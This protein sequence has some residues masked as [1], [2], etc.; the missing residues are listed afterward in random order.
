M[1]DCCRPLTW[2]KEN[3][4][5]LAEFTCL[6]KC[7][8]LDAKT[9]FADQTYVFLSFGLSLCLSAD[10]STRS[11][12]EFEQAIKDCTRS[13]DQFIAVSY[14][15]AS[16]GQTGIGHF[17]PAGGYCSM[18]G[19]MVLILDVAR[20]K[21]GSQNPGEVSL[22][23]WED[24]LRIGFQ[25]GCYTNPLSLTTWQRTSHGKHPRPSI[26]PP[27]DVPSG[28]SI[29][30][31]PA[32]TQPVPPLLTL[33]ATT[34][35]WP[36]LYEP[37]AN[38]AATATSYDTL[39]DTLNEILQSPSGLPNVTS[40]YEGSHISKLT[41]LAFSPSFDAAVGIQAHSDYRRGVARLHRYFAENSILYKQLR[42]ADE[43]WKTE[44]TVF[45]LALVSARDM[46]ERMRPAVREEVER[47]TR[48]DLGDP[49]IEA[50][51]AMVR[52]QMESL[53]EC[54]VEDG[55]RASRPGGCCGGNKCSS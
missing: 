2:V 14:S 17:S 45:M 25:S 11:F 26:F 4:I 16:L 21:Y 49:T 40:R 10:S 28:Y 23:D 33:N 29:L 51:V 3:G 22:T 35:I 43:L 53:T 37:L 31:K 46:R 41:S 18:Y 48:E 50:E 8:G 47:R 54:S 38:V 13:A 19:G 9:R 24:I 5:T 36:T 12:E 39:I 42:T 34:P 27:A 44:I 32:S 1:L 52:R 7:N 20:F 30:R 55:S 6:A 15:R